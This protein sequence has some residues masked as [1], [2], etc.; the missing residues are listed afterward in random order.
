VAQEIHKYQDS[1]CYKL[2][3]LSTYI[4]NINISKNAS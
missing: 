1:F 2:I 4:V 3:D